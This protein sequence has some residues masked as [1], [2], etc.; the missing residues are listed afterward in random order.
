VFPIEQIVVKKE[1]L[2]E[3]NL[4]LGFI[5]GSVALGSILTVIG[6]LLNLDFIMVQFILLIVGSLLGGLNFYIY[7]NEPAW[8]FKYHAKR[9]QQ[10]T[11]KEVIF[12]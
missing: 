10:Q 11:K 12:E 9:V 7:R 6:D 5:G 2:L 8:Y 1:K 4:T 3:S